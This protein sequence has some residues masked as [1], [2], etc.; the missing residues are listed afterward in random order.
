MGSHN[1]KPASSAARPVIFALLKAELPDVSR[2]LELT[3][4]SLLVGSLGLQAT[5]AAG[6]LRWRQVVE[7]QQQQEEEEALTPYDSKEGLSPTEQ[8]P[9]NGGGRPLKDPRL[10]GWE[11]KIVRASRDIF[12]DPTIFR[13]LCEEEALSGWILLEK[14]DDHRVRFKRPIALREVIKSEKLP[15]DP[16]R[17][18][19]GR[20]SNWATWLWGLSFLVALVLPAYLGFALVSATLSNS[21]PAQPGSSPVASPTPTPTPASQLPLQSP[22]TT[23]PTLPAPQ[24]PPAVEPPGDAPTN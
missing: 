21:H 11:F 8:P 7:E 12:R 19:F 1:N 2:M 9:A 14:L 20:S 5:I 13:R 16:Y 10:M 24:P 3:I 17:T 6:W 23:S 18:Q 15:V 4:W 22:S